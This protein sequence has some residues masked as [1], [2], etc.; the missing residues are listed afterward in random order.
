MV[1]LNKAVNL[2]LDEAV[3]KEAREAGLNLSTVAEN[4]IKEAINRLRGNCCQNTTNEVAP[5]RGFEPL[6]PKGPQVLQTCALPG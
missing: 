3:C 1:N 4:A 2:Y 5:G 6:R